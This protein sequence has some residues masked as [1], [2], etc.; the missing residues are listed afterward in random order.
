MQSICHDKPRIIAPGLNPNF[1]GSPSNPNEGALDELKRRI[2]RLA[3][4]REAE[5]SGKPPPFEDA[6]DDDDPSE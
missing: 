6:E 3:K 4:F 5:K 1:S 2:E